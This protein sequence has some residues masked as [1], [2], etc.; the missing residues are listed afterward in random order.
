MSDLIDDN[1]IIPALSSIAGITT[2]LSGQTY[3]N[4]P[5]IDISCYDVIIICLSGGKDSIACLLHLIDI[6]VDLSRVELWHHDVDGREGST[7]M[8]WP[9]MA[10]YNRK[11]ASAFQIPLMFSWLQGGMEGEMLK[12]NGYSRPQCI[13]TPDGL[14]IAERDIQRSTPATRLRFPQQ[15]PSLKTR[16]CSSALKIDVGRRA[17]TNQRRFDGKKVLFI[18]GE[19]RAESSN[20]FNY[21]QLEPHTSSCKK[22]Q[23]DAWRPVLEWSEEQVWEILEKHRVTA[24]VPYRLGWGRSSCLTCIYN[25]A[26]I[27]ATIKHY[28][29]E[30]IHAMASYEDRFGVTISRKRINVLDLSQNISPI[31]ITDEE[32][33]LQA[34][35]PV[36]TLPVISMTKEWL[37]PGGAYNREKCG[38]D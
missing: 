31:N 35:N 23:V 14:I 2:P 5:D 20:R 9:F 6:G 21:L 10:D 22:R 13:E 32:A 38:S 26:R 33:L 3:R 12:E 1:F 27:W 16:W 17:L 18:T 4:A 25:S 8:D 37:L 28:F 15:S 30:R 34:V 24:P 7:L 11:I 36:Y 29:P 19:R